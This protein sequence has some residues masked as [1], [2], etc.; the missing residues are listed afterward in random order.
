MKNKMARMTETLG[1][2]RTVLALSVA[3]MGDGIGNSILFILIPLYIVKL[4]APWL[5][6]SQPMRA[7]LLISLYGLVNAFLQPLAGG[8]SD[9]LN[10]R[11]P[12]IQGGLALMGASIL[13]FTLANR[14][15]DLVVL[16]ALQGIGAALTIPATMAVMTAVTRKETRGGAM[17]V[18]STFR[19]IGLAIGPVIGGFMH[20]HFGF[21]AAFYV[22]VSFIVVAV[23]L[24]RVWV[25]EVTTASRSGEKR[26]FRL[27]DPKLLTPGITGTA[28]AS[29]VMASAFSMMTPLEKQFD[30]R[31][32]Q[33]ALA[34]SIAF[35]ALMVSRL[36]F[37]IPLGWL[38]DR[39]GRKPLIMGGLLLLAPAT[40]LLGIATTTIQLTGFR[41][42]QG[43]AS[44]AIA[45][46]AFALAGDLSRA[47]CE[48]RQMSIITMGF[49]FG[50]A[51]GP[52]IAGGLSGFFFDLPFLVVGL[53]SVLA[54]WIV[55]RYVPE[56]VAHRGS[57]RN[58][59]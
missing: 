46:P 12:F 42:I 25:Q 48:G 52:L 26:P 40:A 6:I 39:I 20:D 9:R 53:M 33:T 50:L 47:G 43:A 36:L 3:R 19:M 4:P 14:F 29:F 10:R 7:G 1:V 45:A 27:I 32:H 24:V 49:G 28:F 16:R 18:F 58:T 23:I 59:Q 8:M 22:G 34:F 35:S 31:I 54:A 17:G 2:N 51:F 37:Q 38:S 5:P 57:R 15:V 41:V 56:T 44:A 13:G 30:S 21:N 11:L 55:Y